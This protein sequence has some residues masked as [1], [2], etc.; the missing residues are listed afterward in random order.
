MFRFYIGFTL[1]NSHPE[2]W[3][4]MITTVRF[5][6]ELKGLFQ[7][8]DTTLTFYGDG[9]DL[10]KS[11]FETYGYGHK[12]TF[13]IRKM[14]DDGNYYPVFSGLIFLK[15]VE[16]TEGTL[17]TFAK[18][19][20]QDNS[21]YA[22]IF[23]NR[24]LKAKVYAG[25]SKNNIDITPAL[26]YRMNYFNPAT[27]NYVA[28]YSPTGSNVRTTTC[29]KVYDVLRYMVDF[30]SDGTVNFTSDI[31]DAGGAYE[32]YY[33]SNGYLAR[34]ATP[35]GTT[36]EL[37]QDNWDELSFTDILQ[38]L[39]IEFNTG[40]IISYNG[41][42]STIRIEEYNY[43]FQETLS[44]S[45]PDC[46]KITHKAASEYLYGS[47]DVGSEIV[48]DEPYLSFPASIRLVGFEKQTYIL[49]GEANNDR[50]LNLVNKWIIDSNTIEDLVVN[51]N[52]C[53]TSYDRTFL[54]IQATPDTGNIV[55]ADQSNWLTGAAT[56]VFYNETLNSNNKL[57]R[58]LGA[59]PNS[60]AMALSVADNTFSA[61]N[62]NQLFTGTYNPAN[63][64]VELSDP[65]NNYDPSGKFYT[66][67]TSG[68]YTFTL[69]GLI[70]SFGVTCLPKI[71]AW[72]DI[73]DA[74]DTPGIDTP[75]TSTDISTLN[76][77]LSSQCVNIP[78][79]FSRAFNLVAT[80]KV[81]M[82]LVLNSRNTL[83]AGS[84]FSVSST[85]DGGGTYKAYD[86]LDYPIVRST[87][88]DYPF[89]ITRYLDFVSN[90]M[91]QMSFN[92]ANGKV[93]YGNIEEFK[94]RLYKE[95]IS[96]AVFLSTE[97]TNQ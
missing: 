97:R 8:M 71:E 69:S 92:I 22:K 86:P 75:I 13:E 85:A 51:Y 10:L 12:E 67:P 59:I 11:R 79:L 5:D 4:D 70:T 20:I 73:Y 15:D 16:F 91:G 1:I 53:P 61:S 87:V 56:P 90:P 49:Q 23:N 41:A 45:L 3:E 81:A 62:P 84:V 35:G 31:F 80:N 66:A 21:F 95:E 6:K 96:N 64:S 42:T 7:I 44:D 2:G 46:E 37:F 89:D 48:T 83:K 32:N 18:C 26:Y 9:H 25:K 65:N 76:G 74:A 50:V 57:T 58:Y 30:M 33:I 72:I 93:Y 52:T 43:L 77:S 40:F 55:K 19:Q 39:N 24:N 54:L 14:L 34:F 29:F 27:G 88:S 38:E 82:R 68:V 36:Q 60:I 28:L 63:Y 78:F 94:Y 47:V 17:G